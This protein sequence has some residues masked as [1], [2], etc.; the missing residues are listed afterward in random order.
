M[1]RRLFDSMKGILP[2]Q[3]KCSH[4]SCINCIVLKLKIEKYEFVCPIERAFISYVEEAVYNP[5]LF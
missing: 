2:Y 1:C 5:E 4:N 3:L